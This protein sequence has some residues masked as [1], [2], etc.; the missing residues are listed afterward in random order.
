MT[1]EAEA[2]ELPEISAPRRKFGGYFLRKL[3]GHPLGMFGLIVII[4]LGIIWLTAPWITPYR[5]TAQDFDLL[6]GPTL[7]HPFGTD[8]LGRDVLSRVLYATRYELTIA[9]TAVLTGVAIAT[10]LGLI[11]GYFGGAL[12]FTAQRVIDSW[13]AFPA[14]I[15][16]MIIASALGPSVR[17]LTIAL[18]IGVIPGTSRVIRGSVLSEKNNVYVEAARVMGASHPRIMFRHILPQVVAPIIVIISIMIPVIALLGAALSFLGLGVPPPTPS[19]GKD[20]A[21]AQG[22]YKNAPWMAIFPG[23][24]ISLTVLSFNM[25]GDAMRDIFDPRLRGSMR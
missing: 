3:R 13:L 5:P 20:L 2:L 9:L 10:V 16:L 12:D 22:F 15:L 24:A 25:L 7:A 23:L 21:D 1:A 8:R 6:Q 19:W 4:L 17:T 14:L 11:S 18:I